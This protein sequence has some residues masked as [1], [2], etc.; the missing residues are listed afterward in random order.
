MTFGLQKIRARLAKVARYMFVTAGRTIIRE[1]HTP[2]ALLFILDGEV[3][4]SRMM[5]NPVSC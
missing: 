4:V 1:G 2:T 5:Y 3:S